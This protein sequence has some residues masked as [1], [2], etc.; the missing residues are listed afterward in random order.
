MGI[1]V[2][3]VKEAKTWNRIKPDG[4]LLLDTDNAKEYCSLGHHKKE[5]N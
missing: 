4:L 5:G 3:L 1:E 2:Y